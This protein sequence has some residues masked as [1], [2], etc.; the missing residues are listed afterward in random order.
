V[1][2]PEE[3]GSILH[4]C[5]GDFAPQDRVMFLTGSRP[6]GARALRAEQVN[7][8]NGRAVL[9]EHKTRGKPGEPKS[10][11]RSNSALGIPRAGSKVEKVGNIP[12]AG[13]VEVSS[14]YPAW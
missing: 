3:F 12:I 1:L 2:T 10:I 5:R 14:P 8:Q 6:G 7:W 9:Q 13:E 4:E 11:C